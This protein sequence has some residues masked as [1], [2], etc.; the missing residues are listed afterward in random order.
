VT[1]ARER[2]NTIIDGHRYEMTMLGATA[3]YQLFHRLFKMLGPS[4]G[5][6]MDAAS[7]SGGNIQDVDLSSEVVV[8]GINALTENVKQDD[9]DHVIAQLKDQTQVGVNGSEQT[10]PLKGVFEMHYAGNIGS[11]FK[12]LYW[13][14]TVQ[15]GSFT[16]A[17]ASVP[18]PSKGGPSQPPAEKSPTP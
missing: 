4:F 2:Q 3:G 17:F 12:W 14:L 1:V 16:D 15:F 6:L 5:A 8:A 10:V 7:Q 13:G 18:T 11:M 9:L